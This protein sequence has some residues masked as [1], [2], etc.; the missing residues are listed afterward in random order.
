MSQ[1]SY[2]RPG[3][4][5]GG[6]PRGTRNIVD[7]RVVAGIVVLAA[8]AVALALV[9]GHGDDSTATAGPDRTATP[10]HQVAAPTD[11]PADAG[12]LPDPA[13]PPDGLGNDPVLDALATDCYGGDMQS[14]DDL[15]DR[16]DVGSDYETYGDSC[17]GRQPVGTLVDCTETFPQD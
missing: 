4:S 17:A 15:F 11:E 6:P 16:S 12:E 5:G 14:C 13:A 1:P 3:V 2:P 9:L 8:V 7:A 10:R